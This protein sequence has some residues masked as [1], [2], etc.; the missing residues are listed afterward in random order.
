MRSRERFS[1]NC[2]TKYCFAFPQHLRSSD[3]DWLVTYYN[4]Q[5]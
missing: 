5:D 3:A 1:Y 4:D 2:N